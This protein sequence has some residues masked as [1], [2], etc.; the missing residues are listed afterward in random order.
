MLQPLLD[1]KKKIR[2]NLRSKNDYQENEAQ[3]FGPFL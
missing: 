3:E 2:V 1:E